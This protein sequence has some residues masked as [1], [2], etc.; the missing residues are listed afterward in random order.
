MAE[1]NG[2]VNGEARMED[3]VSNNSTSHLGK[4]KRT[5]T[6]EP[7]SSPTNTKQASLQAV[8]KDTLLLIRKYV[9]SLR[10]TLRIANLSLQAR[11]VAF[12]AEIPNSNIRF[13]SPRREE[14]A[15][16]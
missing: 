7:A 13:R 10:E 4:R 16:C 15:S 8:L 12:V 1:V 3:V 9:S 6:P 14:S 11:Y 2:E 5:A